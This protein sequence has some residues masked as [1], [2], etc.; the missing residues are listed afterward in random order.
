M[1]PEEVDKAINECYV[2]GYHDGAFP[3]EPSYS[4]SFEDIRAEMLKH[5]AEL[6]AE[7]SKP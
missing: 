3:N 4:Q 2:A 1:T 6:R 7:K 5:D